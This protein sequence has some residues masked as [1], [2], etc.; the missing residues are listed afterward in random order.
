MA[1]GKELQDA[2]A[3]DEARSAGYEN[4]LHGCILGAGYTTP[5]QQPALS[6]AAALSPKVDLRILNWFLIE[7]ITFARHVGGD[8]ACTWCALSGL[9]WA[10]PQENVRKNIGE[11]NK[12]AA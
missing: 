12:Q 6:A 9:R 3:A 2:M 8:P 10:N 1:S 11:T 4:G 5:R 7:N